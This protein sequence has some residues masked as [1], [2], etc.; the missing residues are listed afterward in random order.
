MKEEANERA[1]NLEHAIDDADLPAS[2]HCKRGEEQTEA[3]G[4]QG[5]EIDEQS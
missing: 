1:V 3:G 2:E 5:P 4:G